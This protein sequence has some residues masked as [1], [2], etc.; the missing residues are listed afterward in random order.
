MDVAVLVVADAVVEGLRVEVQRTAEGDSPSA[1]LPFVVLA[2]GQLVGVVP[3]VVLELS[4]C[5]AMGGRS[6]AVEAG[7]YP[8]QTGIGNHAVGEGEVAETEVVVGVEV[9]V[10][11]ARFDVL[12][13]GMRVEHLLLGIER[14]HTH[15]ERVGPLRV[16]CR[17]MQ[18][19]CVLAYVFDEVGGVA[20]GKR[21]AVEM[22]VGVFAAIVE[23][24][25]AVLLRCQCS[26][27]FVVVPTAVELDDIGQETAF[28]V[29]HIAEVAAEVVQVGARGQCLGGQQSAF[30]AQEAVA[31]R[32]SPAADVVVVVGYVHRHFRILAHFLQMVHGQDVAV[33]VEGALLRQ[34]G[35]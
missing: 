16:A 20:H 14:I 13:I 5:C 29:P 18:V 23:L 10:D 1:T 19:E 34:S 28:G 2:K 4:A 15:R 33:V 21:R 8:M 30:V 12:L 24:M 9:G 3:K 11:V 32:G 6:E 25:G 31:L 35:T 22:L 27:R 26:L 7:F 17:E